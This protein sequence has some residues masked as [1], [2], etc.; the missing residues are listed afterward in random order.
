MAVFLDCSLRD[1]KTACNKAAACHYPGTSEDYFFCGALYLIPLDSL[2][3]RFFWKDWSNGNLLMRRVD[4]AL[5]CVLPPV[6]L[7][8]AVFQSGAQ[9]FGVLNSPCSP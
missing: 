2:T 9:C 3:G 6:H 8:S 1:V 7:H 5:S 4:F